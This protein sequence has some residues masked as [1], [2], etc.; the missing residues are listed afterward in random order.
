MIVKAVLYFNESKHMRNEKLRHARETRGWTQK[1]VADNI[2]LP[3]VRSLRRWERGEAFPTLYYRAKLCALFAMNAE[4]L[5]LVP[6]TQEIKDPSWHEEF[7]DSDQPSP[8]VIVSRDRNRQ[9]I[10]ERVYA[11]WIKGVFEQSLQEMNIIPLHFQIQPDA[12]TDPWVH[13]VRRPEQALYTIPAGKEIIQVYEEAYRE[14]LILGEPGS[15][16]TMLLLQLANYLLKRAFADEEH[17]IPIVLNLSSWSPKHTQFV[18]WLIDELN[19]RYH[20]PHAVGQ[21]WVENDQILPLLDGMDEVSP[22]TLDTCINAIN[23]FHQTHS[24]VPLV[25]CTRKKEYFSTQAR[26]MLQQAVNILPLTQ[27]QIENVLNVDKQAI[28]IALREDQ[29]LRDIVTTPLMLRI[30]VTTYHHH[31]LS[32]LQP[33]SLE[34]QRQQMITAYIEQ[35]L[36]HQRSK[37]RSSQQRARR[38]LAWLALQMKQHYQSEFY[39]ERMQ[40]DWLP[41]PRLQQVCYG[42]FSGL[43]A[44]IL[45]GG[46]IGFID[47][48][49]DGPRVALIMLP[50]LALIIG[51]VTGIT[52]AMLEHMLS[53]TL[54]K[55][56]TGAGVGS[57]AAFFGVWANTTF[58][59]D[60]IALGVVVGATICV[61]FILLSL[62]M[63][64]IR[65]TEAISWSWKRVQKTFSSFL[66][67]GLLLAIG[68]G[69]IG[70]LFGWFLGGLGISMI[71]ILLFG[72]LSF[73]IAGFLNG[74]SSRMID[75][76]IFAHPNQG[77]Y[78]SFYYALCSGFVAA[79]FTWFVLTMIG[80]LFMRLFPNLAPKPYFILFS[81]LAFAITTGV[82]IGVYRG[83]AASLK[84]VL[85]RL[86]LWLGGYIPWNY[87]QFLDEAARSILLR[88]VGGGYIFIHQLVLDHFASLDETTTK[89]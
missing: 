8:P 18:S 46:L 19:T 56:A 68:V 10:L 32:D 70:G 72:G 77:I 21:S 4:D 30:L 9:R 59:Y 34:T 28:Q 49:M 31:A 57:I 78:R 45:C 89:F 16:K 62:K 39:L 42:L 82:L 7:S 29:S 71:L 26:L 27:Q 75:E 6:G 17:P 24:L 67:T 80:I 69:T 12:L 38:Q 22:S 87:Q 83:G 86:F 51:I 81:E 13:I 40:L 3:D 54:R 33:G 11:F 35:M 50:C 60:G 23:A 52:G 25:I 63:T 15:G 41:N 47:V 84:H 55:V 64:E 20:V 58:I 61:T 5:Q 48:P 85:L 1:D 36:A 88:K 65:P 76:H 66:M 43:W 37:T 74:L 79:T 2:D 73:L 14:L 53:T 44:G